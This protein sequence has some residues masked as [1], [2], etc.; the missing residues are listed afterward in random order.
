MP[1]KKPAPKPKRGRPTDCTPELMRRVE[2]RIAKQG[3][4]FR[5]AALIEGVSSTAHFEW[6]KKGKENPDSAYG[7]YA[8]MGE[9]A[10]ELAKAGVVNRQYLKAARGDTPAANFVMKHWQAEGFRSVNVGVDGVDNE[11]QVGEVEVTFKIGAP[12]PARAVPSTP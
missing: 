5:T 6:L 1:R 2:D 3:L 8:K 9:K 10:A 4:R 11:G 7:D 12:V